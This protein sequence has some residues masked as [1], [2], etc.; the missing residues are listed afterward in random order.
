MFVAHF[1]QHLR[2]KANIVL[3]VKG[4]FLIKCLSDG[5]A[6]KIKKKTWVILK[7]CLLNWLKPQKE[8]NHLWKFFLLHKSLFCA[9]KCLFYK[10]NTTLYSA[11]APRDKSFAAVDVFLWFF[12]LFPRHGAWWERSLKAGWSEAGVGQPLVH[13]SLLSP[14]KCLDGS[15][16]EN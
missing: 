3:F 9:N 7:L 1:Q 10:E 4:V 6:F 12:I 13:F 16:S 2:L 8:L 11:V 14:L 5:K 15:V